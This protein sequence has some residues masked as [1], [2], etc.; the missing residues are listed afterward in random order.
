MAASIDAIA[1]EIDTDELFALTAEYA[2]IDAVSGHEQDL[3]RRLRDDLAPLVDEFF[4]DPFGNIAGTRHG[5]DRDTSLMIAAH[6]DEIGCLVKSI[7]ASGMVRI[8]P[9]GG[10]GE[11]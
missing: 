8:A 10:V 5:D 4:I 11:T 2:A 6:S 7:E 9:V 3:V 1:G